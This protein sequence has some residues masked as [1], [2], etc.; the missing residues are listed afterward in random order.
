MSW[1]LNTLSFY[2][3]SLQEL[4][5]SGNRIS[6]LSFIPDFFHR[7]EI[8]NISCNNIKSLDE[9]VCRIFRFIKT[10]FLNVHSVEFSLIS[11]KDKVKFELQWT[12]LWFPCKLYKL[13]V[14]ISISIKHIK[15]V[16]Q[17]NL[18]SMSVCLFL[19]SILFL[20]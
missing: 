16:Y 3:R 10:N 4:Y 11:N 2:C 5:A 6:D 7:L 9:V 15:H 19:T 8:F 13:I 18:Q 17:L 12:T 20:Y 1:P 14:K